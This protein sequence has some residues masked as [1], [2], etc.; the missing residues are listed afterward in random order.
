MSDKTTFYSQNFSKLF[1]IEIS[2]NSS[3]L[4]SEIH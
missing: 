4:R 1:I 3:K 2:F